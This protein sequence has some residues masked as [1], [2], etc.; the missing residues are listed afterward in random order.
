MHDY[1]VK[2]LA[3]STLAIPAV[4]IVAKATLVL[5]AAGAFAAGAAPRL[6]R[7]AAPRLVP[8]PG[9]RAGAARTFPGLARVVTGASCRSQWRPAGRFHRRRTR[10]TSTPRIAH[11]SAVA[12]GDQPRRGDAPARWSG[13]SPP[14]SADGRHREHAIRSTLGHLHSI[15]VMDVGRVADRGRDRHVGAD[16]RPNRLASVGT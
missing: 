10:R 5:A 1:L 16:R 12:R 8:R 15:V 3:G 9:C 4:D 6:C 2:L 13:G 7:V 14:I 11:G